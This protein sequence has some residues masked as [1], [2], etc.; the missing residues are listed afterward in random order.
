[1]MEASSNTKKIELNIAFGCELLIE[2]KNVGSRIK[3]TLIGVDPKSFIIIKTPDIVGIQ[4]CLLEGTVVTIRYLYSGIVYGFRSSIRGSITV[5][6]RLLFLQFPKRIEKINLRKH[7]RITCAMPVTFGLDD[8]TLNG[9]I[10]D[11]ST[12]GCRLDAK[13]DNTNNI[14]LFQAKDV[15]ILSFA[16]LGME[17][18][19][20][21]NGTVRNANY[22]SK[23]FSLGIE[24]DK[25]QTEALDKIG[26]YINLVKNPNGEN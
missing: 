15:V 4:K 10:S 17:S 19:V 9:I 22:D 21:V 14:I 20:I 12:G 11:L 23:T 26:S 13:V 16:Q 1:M 2:I 6:E 8:L 5:P 24:F 7:E 25:T 18:N 3:S